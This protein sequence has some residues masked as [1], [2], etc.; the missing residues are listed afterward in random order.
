MSQTIE[1]FTPG[2][3]MQ[4][5]AM[6]KQALM[7]SAKAPLLIGFSIMQIFALAVIGVIEWEIIYEVFFYLSGDTEGY[8]APG[9]MG[10]TAGVMIVGFH[11]LAKAKPENVAVR[12]VE[13]AVQ[14]L[15]P[16]YL[17]GI[18]L[19]IAAIL[20]SIGLGGMVASAPE[21]TFG[22]LPKAIES[23]W[24]ELVFTDIANPGAVLVFA[25][26]IGGIAII[27]IFVS[28]RLLLLIGNNLSDIAGRLSRAKEALSDFRIIKRSQKE[29]SDLSIELDALA[30]NDDAY[31]RLKIAN[32][33]IAVIADALHPHKV[34][35]S[36][37]S[38]D[39]TSRFEEEDRINANQISKEIS[40]IEAISLADVLAALN[41]KCLEKKP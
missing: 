32:D 9:L 40:R 16:I 11:L 14:I 24:L 36:K 33:V 1:L 21:L 23:N 18:G 7:R 30:A 37:Q 20:Y 34:W 10:C 39:K 8:W 5:Q 29:Y 38:L 27:N 13:G 17:A 19:L 41:P 31:I 28:H 22:E 15:I 3:Q 6:V 35:L 25:L 4:H 2:E 26:G 12:I